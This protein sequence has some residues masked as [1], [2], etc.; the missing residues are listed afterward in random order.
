VF[1]RSSILEEYVNEPEKDGR[2]KQ[3]N[4]VKFDTLVAMAAD[5]DLEFQGSQTFDQYFPDIPYI[6]LSEPV[7]RFSAVHR[8]FCFR[9]ISKAKDNGK[10]SRQEIRQSV[11]NLQ[12]QQFYS[13]VVEDDRESNS[14]AYNAA[15]PR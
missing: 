5:F 14:F 12:Q 3:E 8:T 1:I 4:L 13:G 15:Y 2:L 9:K 10:H 7:A 6:Q 11:H